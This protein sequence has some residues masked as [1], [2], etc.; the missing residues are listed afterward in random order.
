M[1]LVK[2]QSFEEYTNYYKTFANERILL[3]ERIVKE[4]EENEQD[5]VL[6]YCKVC[7]K[8]TKFKIILNQNNKTNLRESLVCE[9]CNLSNRKR[10]MLSFLNEFANKSNSKLNVFMYEQVTQVFKRS[11]NVKNINLVGSEFLGYDKKPGQIIENIRNEDAMNL[12][13]EN[14]SFEVLISNDVYEHIPNI[15]K[16]LS[17]AYR[18]LKNSGTLLISIP[19]DGAKVKTTRRATLEEGKIK[20][21]QDPIYHENP[22]AKKEGSLVF[23]EYGWD[24][25]DFLKTAGF[26]DAH[27]LNY[28]DM[29]YGYLGTVDTFIFV[30]VK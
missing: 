20:H 12:S 6:G 8:A 22:I 30:A 9:Y 11:Q 4:F 2:L 25:L 24:F 29:F 13:S 1:N 21:L 15:N 26:K 10:F 23:Y 14:N 3:L 28:F 5:F 19:F 17:E 27:M 16:A 7:N 18:V